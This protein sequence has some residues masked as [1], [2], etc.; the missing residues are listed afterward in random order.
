[1]YLLI[2]SVSLSAL[3]GIGI[4]LFGSFGEL[5]MKVLLTTV[6]IT[7]MS[8]LGLACGASLE[9]GDGKYLPGAGIILS[10]IA[11][12]SW[13]I[14]IW[15]EQ[16]IGEFFAKSVMSTTILAVGFS[17][18][19]LISLARLDQRFKW[20][21]L[22]VFVCVTCLVAILLGLIWMTN[23]F[24]G[25][26]TF[27]ILGVLSIAVSAL[28]IIIPV[29]HKLSEK[30]NEVDLINEEIEKLKTKISE[31]EKRKEKISNR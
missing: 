14:L 16:A 4:I 11:G 21:I 19:S 2:T 5:E 20:A 10:I 29:F 27:R 6:A 1:L 13:I 30:L 9:A 28:T 23:T 26:L 31:L 15:V 18:L 8:I 12:V 7:C 3:L 22:S 25:D 17:H 24:E